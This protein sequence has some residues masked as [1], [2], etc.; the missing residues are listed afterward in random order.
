MNERNDL[1]QSDNSE[2]AT[3]LQPM[4]FADILDGM[5]SLY[6]S[7]WS[8]FLGITGVYFILVYGMD[9]IS[10]FALVNAAPSTTMVVGLLAALGSYVV[11]FWVVAGLVYASAEAYLNRDLT[12]QAALKHAWR[13]FWSYVGSVI[14]WFLVVC[15]LFITIIG[16][17]FSIYFGVRWGLYGLPVMCEGTTARH[18]LRRSTELVKGTW[19]R[20]FGIMLAIFLIAIMIQFIF[21]T[22]FLLLAQVSGTEDTTLW[23]TFRRLFIPVPNQIEWRSYIIQRF[24]TIGIAA[25]TMPL[26]AIGSALLYFDLRIRKEAFDIEM[27]VTD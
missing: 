20:A 17:P 1:V 18:A 21:Q 11:I 8:L 7:H 6:R 15:G 24:I 26:G 27:Q 5:F 25:L 2:A 13:R 4:S 14:L 10:I 9:L 3:P 23:E 12:S 22:S 16:I 19:W